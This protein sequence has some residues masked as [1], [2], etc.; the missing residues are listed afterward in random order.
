MRRR[1]G[2]TLLEIMIY[3][4][5]AGMAALCVGAMFSL[6]RTAQNTTLSGD[7]MSGQAD[8][9]LRWVRQKVQES[10]LSRV[11]PDPTEI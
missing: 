8:N 3:V 11:T 6:R 2:F 9:T 10:P 1:A 4:V 5:M 7:L